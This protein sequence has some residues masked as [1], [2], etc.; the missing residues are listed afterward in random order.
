MATKSLRGHQSS[1]F[2]PTTAKLLAFGAS[3]KEKKPGKWRD[4]SYVAIPAM[5]LA[6]ISNLQK[7][8]EWRK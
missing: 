2:R 6:A 5:K 8:D 1:K 4:P 3:K 7:K